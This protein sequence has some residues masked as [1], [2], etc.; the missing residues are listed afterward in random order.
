[1]TLK[2]TF[3]NIVSMVEPAKPIKIKPVISSVLPAF[4]FPWRP[5]MQPAEKVIKLNQMFK[6]CEPE[7]QCC[8]SRL[9]HRDER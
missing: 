1:M 2:E 6:D 4:D 3:G 7:K 8:L 9:F 5:G